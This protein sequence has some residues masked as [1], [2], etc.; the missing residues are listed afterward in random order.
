MNGN[1]G[2]DLEGSGAEPLADDD[3]RRIGPIPLIGRLGAGGMGRVFLGVHDGR[4]VAVKQVLPSIAREDEEFLL[5]FGHEL[6][7]LA[8]LP[9]DATARLIAG[10]RA[11][12]LPWFATAYVPGITLRESVDSHGPLPAEALWLLLREAADGLA[13]IHA[14]DMVHRD[15]KPSNAMLT[16]DGLTL[17]D[18]GVAHAAQQSRLTSVGVVVGT[19]AYMSPE[20]AQGKR[21]LSGAVDIFALGSMVAYAAT[22]TPPFG[23]ESGP[24]VL[25]RIV[26]EN[27]DLQQLRDLDAELADVVA[28]CLEKAPEGRPTA[29]E[30]I[31][32]TSG[33]GPAVPP[34][35][36]KPV[37]ERL[38]E[39]AAFAA[40]TP[41]LSR[42]TMP[43]TTRPDTS[44]GEESEGALGPAAREPE[45]VREA[46][47]SGPGRAV[48]EPKPTAAPKEH[49]RARITPVII[50][51]LVSGGVGLTAVLL[52][53][54]T[55]AGDDRGRGPSSSVTAP[56]VVSPSVS[57]HSP[58]EPSPS[59]DA[60]A[61]KKPKKPGE[62][63]S[64]QPAMPGASG[65]DQAAGGSDQGS[66]SGG[67]GGNG[68]S[69]TS[70]GGG[71]GG[72]S[73]GTS[74]GGN[75]GSATGSGG[76]SGGS[77][78]TGGGT[79]NP[80]PGRKLVRNVGDGSCV[81]AQTFSVWTGSCAGD[82]AVWTLE[83][84][85]NGTYRFVSKS[86]GNCM[87][88]GPA[89]LSACGTERQGWRL[90]SGGTLVSTRTG[91]CL[92]AT[93][94]G[95]LFVRDCTGAAAQHWSLS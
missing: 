26:H 40:R 30:L 82:A 89:Q 80:A 57:A 42:F 10:D 88:N 65:G 15:V 54:V 17:I 22:G 25:Y 5:R 92:E 14:L 16:P 63:G 68:G 78:T 19:A 44:D 53:Y 20:Q 3:P 93:S 36:P 28:D 6:D 27:P 76:G 77:S 79:T 8:R 9:E 18:F 7:N 47:E 74:G 38:S 81:V 95:Q 71:G 46:A 69:G 83:S 52:P 73:S 41:D 23:D 90:G 66:D 48:V 43:D 35:W 32:R 58:E 34:L 45:G 12:R 1:T 21:T 61:S 72:S 55:E 33:R 60:S 70:G 94:Y 86:S 85:G 24:G 50:P 87:T 11:A 31:E 67:G 29:T 51:V 39:R 84:L 91:D 64:G 37:A 2:I 13:A 49:R 4:Y 62:S 56:V 75:G 59:G